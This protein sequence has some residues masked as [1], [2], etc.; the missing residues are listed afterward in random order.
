MSV[1]SSA[2]ASLSRMP[3]HASSPISVS[4]VTARSGGS[5]VLAAAIIAATSA[6]V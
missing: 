5:S 4:I 1:R 6:A 2:N 3:V